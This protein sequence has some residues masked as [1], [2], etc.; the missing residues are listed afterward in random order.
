MYPAP[1]MQTLGPSLG[2]TPGILLK[3][4]NA[5]DKIRKINKCC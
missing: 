2:T 1:M 4:L 5:L 3:I